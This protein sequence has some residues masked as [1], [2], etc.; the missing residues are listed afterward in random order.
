MLFSFRKLSA[1]PVRNR[2]IH[3]N[4]SL[5]KPALLQITKIKTNKETDKE[6]ASIPIT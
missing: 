2:Y 5:A 1:N 6:K 4:N 3:E